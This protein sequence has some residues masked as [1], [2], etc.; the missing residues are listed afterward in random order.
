MSAESCMRA[1]LVMGIAVRYPSCFRDIFVGIGVRLGLTGVN[2]FLRQR[3]C[4]KR[5]GEGIFDA[6]N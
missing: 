6:W 1:G 5:E 2:Q 4:G 3:E